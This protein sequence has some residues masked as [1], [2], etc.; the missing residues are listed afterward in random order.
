MS[1]YDALRVIKGICEAELAGE[2]G[3]P[4]TP[5]P[6]PTTPTTPETPPEPPRGLLSPR[7]YWLFAGQWGDTRAMIEA[8]NAPLPAGWSW[9]DAYASGAITRVAGNQGGGEPDRRSI[10]DL[11]TVNGPAVVEGPAGHV[12]VIFIRRPVDEIVEVTIGRT[13]SAF[14]TLGPGGASISARG[15]KSTGSGSDCYGKIR[16]TSTG[17]DEV[18]VELHQ[19]GAIAVQRN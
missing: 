9:D 5:V 1:A 4:V 17:N 2:L 14:G 10:R 11:S 7:D 16:F 13:N 18:R 6:T 3:A 12:D 15:A 19:A 8:R